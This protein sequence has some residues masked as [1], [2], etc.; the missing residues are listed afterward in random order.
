MRMSIWLETHGGFAVT[1]GG[2]EIPF[3]ARKP[4]MLL[5]L[6]AVARRRTMTSQRLTALLREDNDA[7]LGRISLPQTLTRIRGVVGDGGTMAGQRSS[8]WP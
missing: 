1:K 3:G 2:A 8:A 5:G 4:R 6:F 7:E